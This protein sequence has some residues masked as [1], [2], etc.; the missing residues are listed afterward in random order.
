MG[1]D[2]SS[3][4]EEE[5]RMLESLYH[6]SEGRLDTPDREHVNSQVNSGTS[7]PNC[8]PLHTLR[9]IEEERMR[10]QREEEEARRAQDVQEAERLAGLLDIDDS[11]HREWVSSQ[12]GDHQAAMSRQGSG[13]SA[14]IERTDSLASTGS[15]RSQSSQPEKGSIGS[16]VQMAKTGYQELVNAIIRPPRA[17]YS[18]EHLGPPAFSFLGKRFTRTDFTLQ[19]KRGLN[20]QCS[21]WEPVERTVERIPVVI[22]MHGNAS[23]RVEVLP[24]LTVL[25]SLGVAVFAFD[26]AGSGKSDGEHVT[27]G[28]FEREDLLCVVAHLRATDVVSTIALWGRSMGAVTALMHGDRDPSI[29]GMVLDS[30]FSDLTRLCE[31]MVDKAR[32]QGINVPGFVS[33][34]AIRALR[35][36]VRRQA[37]FDIK[38]VSPITHVPHCF[39]P[40][41]FVAAENDDFITKAHSMSLHDAYAGDANMIV[42]DGDHNS[43]RPRFMFD[44]VSIFLQACLQIPTEWQFQLHPSMNIMLPPWR[45]PGVQNKYDPSSNMSQSTSSQQQQHQMRR[46]NA[47]PSKSIESRRQQQIQMHTVTSPT[48]QLT[49]EDDG[50]SEEEDQKGAEFAAELDLAND[51]YDNGDDNVDDETGIDTEKLGMTSERQREIQG[52]LFRMLGHDNGAA[53]LQREG[54]GKAGINNNG[55]KGRDGIR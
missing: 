38:D 23:A 16:F 6:I 47:S 31:E 49:V 19:T 30:P 28:Y 29:A 1:N 11:R 50:D 26:F 3:V 5:R 13:A 24:Q 43:S 25:L 37:D 17:K 45:Y 9:E 46:R 48:R 2:Q 21:H 8:Q 51:D 27:L 40:A 20:L 36:S 18:E 52:S 42:V 41:L 55:A 7:A 15:T 4:I 10:L 39:I 12:R 33:S 53:P 44:S 54:D 14:R 22:Y 34:V 32:D 35:G